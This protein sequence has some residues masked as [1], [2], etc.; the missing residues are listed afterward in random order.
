[1]Q[2]GLPFS[3][4]SERHWEIHYATKDETAPPTE[5]VRGDD[6][7]KIVRLSSSV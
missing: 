1:M 2:I 5:S 7:A 4:S 3:S 6:Q